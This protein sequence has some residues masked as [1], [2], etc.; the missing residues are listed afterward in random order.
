[1]SWERRSFS[2]EILTFW[3]CAFKNSKEF[4]VVFKFGRIFDAQIMKCEK[5]IENQGLNKCKYCFA[6]ISATK[7]RIFMKFYVAV[8]LSCEL[9]CTHKSCKCVH[10]CFIARACLNDLCASICAHNIRNLFLNH[11]ESPCSSMWKWYCNTTSLIPTFTNNLWNKYLLFSYTK[12]W[13]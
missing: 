11:Y 10:L 7:A 13:N 4:H 6:N 5:C 1:M 12:W 2:N 9:K 3:N 8:N